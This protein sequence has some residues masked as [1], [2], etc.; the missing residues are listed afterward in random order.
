MDDVVLVGVTEGVL[1][2]VWL[3]VG[4]GDAEKQ[5][6]PNETSSI[7]QSIAL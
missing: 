5:S 1:D 2:G 6:A 4:E 3:G 7:A